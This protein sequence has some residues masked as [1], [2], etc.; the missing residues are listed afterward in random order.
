M[1]NRSAS[2]KIGLVL[3]TCLVLFPGLIWFN[4]WRAVN[5]LQAWKTRMIAQGER[6]GIDELAPPLAPNDPKAGE[7]MAAA[8]R[9]RS[10]A[11]D[12]GYFLS[13]DYIAS[14]QARALWLGTNLAGSYR[15]GPVTWSQVTEE[16]KS[17]RDDLET[18]HAALK[19]PVATSVMNYHNLGT[20]SGVVVSKR[21]AAQW[22]ACET[23][24]QLHSRCARHAS[25]VDSAGATA[26]ERP[27][28]GQSNDSR[29]HCR[30]CL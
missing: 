22:L 11:F 23:I 9:L 21:A 27:D 20:S 13:P 18:I 24:E 2:L 14:G 10:H 7:L 12:P 3:G 5:A 25:R 17:A 6:F 19:N 8:N 26:L 1:A 15:H 30:A 4:H 16:M 29:R 28:A